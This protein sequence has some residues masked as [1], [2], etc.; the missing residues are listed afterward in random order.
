MIGTNRQWAPFWDSERPAMADAILDQKSDQEIWDLYGGKWQKSALI[1]GGYEAEVFFPKLGNGGR[2][3]WFTAAPIKSADGSVVGAI[4]TLLDTTAAKRAEEEQ[5]RRNREL[6]TFTRFTRR[7]MR[8]CRLQERIEGAVLEIR[9]FMKA[10]SVCLY[11]S[12]DGGRFDLRYFN[13]C[14]ADPGYGQ[15]GPDSQSEIMRKVSRTDKPIVYNAGDHQG[16]FSSD[17][18][19]IRATFAYI[20]ISA[21]ETKGLGVMRIERETERFSSEELHLLDLMGNR[22]GATI[23]NA[24]LH[25]EIMRKSNSRPN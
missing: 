11:M 20:P 22:I 6:S 15:A 3:C 13:A 4:E 14:Y 12:E 18:E 25:E 5:R 1:D 9:D 16:R 7:S 23:E 24:M 17:A 10:E 2:W 21:K 8:H 19:T